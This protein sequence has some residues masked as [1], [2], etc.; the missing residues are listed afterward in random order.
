MFPF[1][2][3]NYRICVSFFQFH[4]KDSENAPNPSFEKYAPN[5]FVI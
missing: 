1:G 5:I 4:L 3:D 2:T